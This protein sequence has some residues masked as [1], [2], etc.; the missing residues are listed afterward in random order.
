MAANV[1]YGK[2]G[3]TVDRAA[4]LMHGKTSQIRHNDKGLFKGLPNPFTDED[5]AGCVRLGE[6]LSK[7]L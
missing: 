3:A 1:R 2:L 6:I 7:V 5:E 4:E